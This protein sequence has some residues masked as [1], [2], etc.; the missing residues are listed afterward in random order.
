M[1]FIVADKKWREKWD[2]FVGDC[3]SGHFMQS[4]AWGKFKESSG[5]EARYFIAIQ[6]NGI[7]GTALLLA[8]PLPLVKNLIYYL[9]RG[10][11]V[12]PDD[13]RTLSFLLINIRK[14]VKSHGGIFLRADPYLK[15]SE[16]YDSIFKKAGYNKIKR[17]WSYWNSPKYIFWLKLDT[18]L[19]DILRKI[20]KKKRYEIRS[21][22]KKGVKYLKAGPEDLRGFYF[23]MI[24][25][26]SRK[27]IGVHDYGYYEKIFRILGESVVPKLFLAKYEGETVAAGISLIYG[28][29]AWLLYLASGEK[30]LHLMPNRALQWEMI[31][32]ADEQDCELYDFRGTATDD[33]PNPNDSGYGVYKFKKSFR[34]E[35]IKTVGYYDYIGNKLLYKLFIFTENYLIPHSFQRALKISK[36][37]NKF[38]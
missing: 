22:Y 2:Q 18:G 24:E 5:W 16:E 33:P 8:K 11:V 10:P 19:D 37:W 20:H 28:K 25:T 9:P 7:K 29:K 13:S 6:K 21:A 23:L 26:A 31:K 30:H 12:E 4:Y 14:Y 35:F 27:G 36:L 1:R 15:E 17:T 3:P 34:P 32:W 38:F